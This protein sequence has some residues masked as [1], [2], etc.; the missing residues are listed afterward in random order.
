MFPKYEH[1]KP[2]GQM[3]KSPGLWLAI[4]NFLSIRNSQE[5]PTREPTKRPTSR[6]E[7]TTKPTRPTRPEVDTDVTDEPFNYAPILKN[8]ISRISV[9]VGDTLDFKVLCYYLR[10]CTCLLLSTV[11]LIL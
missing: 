1:L 6:P 7:S 4:C 5:P 10:K 11:V 9:K 2:V 3:L 8:D